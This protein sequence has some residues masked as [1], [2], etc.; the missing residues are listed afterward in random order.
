MVDLSPA[1]V[2]LANSGSFCPTAAP[3]REMANVSSESGADIRLVGAER[4]L[5]TESGQLVR[6]EPSATN[7]P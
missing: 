4:L 7:D 3:S 5:H 2:V 1:G 6:I